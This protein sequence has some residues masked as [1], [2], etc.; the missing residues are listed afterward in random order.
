M[1]QNDNARCGPL[2]PVA[3]I[4]ARWEHHRTFLATSVEYLGASV[5]VTGQWRMRIGANYSQCRWWP[6]TTHV[7]PLSQV[8]VRELHRHSLA[9]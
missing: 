6:T 1:S 3:E 5:R 8:R 4:R 2:V 9:A 7:W